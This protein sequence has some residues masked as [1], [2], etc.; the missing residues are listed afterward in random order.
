MH[1]ARGTAANRL[2]SPG[3]VVS[4]RYPPYF[5]RREEERAFNGTPAFLLSTSTEFPDRFLRSAFEKTKRCYAPD[6]FVS[7]SLRPRQG[8][9]ESACTSELRRVS[10][11]RG[12]RKIIREDHHENRSD[13]RRGGRAPARR[14]G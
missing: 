13:R 5:L 12:A 9:T 11:S 2:Q 1:P 4:F 6:F 8:W 7:T 3:S 10:S 14:H